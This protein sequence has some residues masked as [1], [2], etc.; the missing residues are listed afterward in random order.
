MRGKVTFLVCSATR[1]FDTCWNRR[2]L[3]NTLSWDSSLQNSQ[4]QIRRATLIDIVV[5][6]ITITTKISAFSSGRSLKGPPA[7]KKKR[8]VVQSDIEGY[9]LSEALARA[10]TSPRGFEPSRHDIWHNCSL[11]MLY[12][13]CE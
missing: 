7:A 3:L 1:L 4:F 13:M 8:T 12:I 2:G 6:I 9:K 11:T 5:I 10:L